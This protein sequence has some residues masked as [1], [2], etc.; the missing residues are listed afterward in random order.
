MLGSEP[1]ASSVRCTIFAAAFADLSSPTPPALPAA[2]ASP[3]LPG[4]GGRPG[5]AAAA[6]TGGWT[7]MQLLT[8]PRLSSTV[9]AV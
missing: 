7:L 4:S 3:L 8:L 5:S 2:D 9:G 6:P 1:R